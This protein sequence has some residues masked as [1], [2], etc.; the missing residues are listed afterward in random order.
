MKLLELST[1]RKTLAFTLAEVLIV[2]GIIGIVAQMTIPTL[3]QNFQEKVAI[4]QLKKAYSELLQATQM[5]KTEQGDVNNWIPDVGAT[6]NADLVNIYANT[7]NVIKNCTQAGVTDCWASQYKYLNNTNYPWVDNTSKNTMILNDGTSVSIETFGKSG[8][9]TYGKAGT[10]AGITYADVYVD[11]NGPKKPN[12]I[13]QDVFSFFISANTLIPYGSPSIKDGSG[14][15]VATCRKDNSGHGCAAWI[16][17][18]ENM[19]YLKCQTGS[20]AVCSTIHW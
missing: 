18:K 17:Y 9:T 6:G 10:E 13:G 4:T 5:I 20:E 1:T 2:V 15:D 8:S 11:V 19:D 12:V 7:M 14:F 16:L 3:V